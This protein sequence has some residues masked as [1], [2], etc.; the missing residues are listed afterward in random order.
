MIYFFDVLVF[1]NLFVFVFFFFLNNKNVFNIFMINLLRV[2]NIMI[3]TFSEGSV[4]LFWLN[5]NLPTNNLL[6]VEN[7]I[8]KKTF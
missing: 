2:Y 6:P 8:Q 4:S 5:S 1:Y 3:E 7:Q